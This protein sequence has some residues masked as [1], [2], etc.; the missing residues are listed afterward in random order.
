MDVYRRL[1]LIE[2]V[3]SYQ[4]KICLLLLPHFGIT[5]LNMLRKIT[6]HNDYIIPLLLNNVF[7]C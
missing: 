1:K 3:F 4:S 2:N 5:Y 6:V 7:L